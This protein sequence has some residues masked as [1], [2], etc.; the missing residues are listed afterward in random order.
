MVRVA[1]DIPL[2][3]KY[4]VQLTPIYGGVVLHYKEYI[5]FR[6]FITGYKAPFGQGM[7][8]PLLTKPI[9]NNNLVAPS[10]Y[11]IRLSMRASLDEGFRKFSFGNVWIG[12]PDLSNED[13]VAQGIA[14]KVAAMKSTGNR[15]VTNSDVK[16]VLEVPERTQSYEPFITEMRNEFHM[17]MAD[18]SLKLGLE[19]GFTKSTAEAAGKMYEFKISTMRRTIKQHFEDLFVQV[20]DKEG[21]EGELAK[22]QMNFGPEETAEYNIADIFA[23]VDRKVL[24]LKSA[25]N[26]LSKYHKWDISEQNIDAEL[27]EEQAVALETMKAEGE[28]QQK[29]NPK[30]QSNEIGA[31]EKAKA[32]EG[33]TESEE[34]QEAIYAPFTLVEPKIEII[35]LTDSL[36]GISKDGKVVFIDPI[37]E[38]EHLSELLKAFEMYKFP[39]VSKLGMESD[40]ASKLAV[41]HMKALSDKKGYEWEKLSELSINL[42]SKI[43]ERGKI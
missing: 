14:D 41:I 3:E 39:L 5:H 9:Y 12:V 21:F 37:V 30:S 27:K 18:P 23:A 38:S 43:K 6:T 7:I 15:I 11:E 35:Q 2:Q 22:I 17:G 32:K 31:K 4:E 10:L 40:K 20:L 36:S 29:F 16:V 19:E 26:L 8:Q 28:L 13:F 33:K 34:L 25:R 24:S 42:V 1:P